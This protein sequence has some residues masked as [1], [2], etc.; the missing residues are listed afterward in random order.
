MKH[1]SWF[2]LPPTVEY[3]YKQR[4][5][6]YKTLPPFMSNCVDEYIRPLDIIYPDE[7]ARIYVPLEISGQRGKTIFTA[8]NRNNNSKLFWHLDDTYIGTTT[9]FHQ[10]AVNPSPG[11]HTLTIVDENGDIVTR[12]FEI[13]QKK[14][15]E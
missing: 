14:K 6:D 3:Y 13:M 15:D 8:T 7:N 5:A 4:H 12:H 11:L 10:M 9:Q 2:V 1:V